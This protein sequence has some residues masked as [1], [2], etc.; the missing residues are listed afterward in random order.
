MPLRRAFTLV[1][2]L[3]VIAIIA[4]LAA[5]LLPALSAAKERARSAQCLN[6]QHQ[7]ALGMEMY[8]NGNSDIF[9]GIASKANGY[10][11]EDWIYWRTNAALYPP[12]EKSPIIAQSGTVSRSMFRCP[13]DQ[14]DV[15][16]IAQSQ[17]SVGPYFYSYSFTGYGDT[18]YSASFFGLSGTANYGMSSITTSSGVNLL[19]KMNRVHNPSGKIMLAEEPGSMSP[20]DTPYTNWIVAQDGRFMP[21]RDALTIRHGGKAEV[22][23]ADGHVESVTWKF[24]AD[25]NNSLP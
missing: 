16:R 23:F 3:V 15:D 13:S 18:N 7:L 5:L 4:I 14:S 19:F 25:W 24:G 17:A 2:L 21:D 11:P 8:I 6:N 20:K 9:P 22:A 10:Q 1:E 12:V